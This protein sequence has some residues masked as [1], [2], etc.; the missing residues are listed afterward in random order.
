M[1]I[2]SR[3]KQRELECYGWLTC[4]KQPRLFDYRIG[5]V[6]KLAACQHWRP[7]CS[8][9]TDT[10][11]R[12]HSDTGELSL[13]AWREHGR[14]RR[15]NAVG[16]ARKVRQSE[17][18]VLPLCHVTN[19][20]LSRRLKQSVMLVGSH[21]KSGRLP[22]GPLVPV[23]VQSLRYHSC[24]RLWPLTQAAIKL[25]SSGDNTRSSVQHPL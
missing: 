12:G 3:T 14:E 11:V 7:G 25:P 16:R 2:K 9:P 13:L 15:A 21:M 22:A 24:Q 18:D 10:V 1:Y 23:V 5:V 6:N 20:A 4:S 17:T 19:Y 8:D